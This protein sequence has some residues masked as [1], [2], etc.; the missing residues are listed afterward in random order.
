MLL[1]L[2]AVLQLSGC[3]VS[4]RLKPSDQPSVARKTFVITGASSGFGRGVALKLAALQGDVVLAARRTDVL[5]E[6]A[7]QIRMAG[8]SALVVTTDVSNPNEMQDLARAAIE[9]FGRIDVWINNAAVGALGRFEDVPVEDHAR[10]VDVNLKG[11]IYGSHAAMRQFR[12]QGFGTLV[13]VGSV[14]SEIP[15]A[16]HAS[17]AATKGGVINLGA[18]I[19]EE[20][21]LSGSETINVATV[22]P[23]AVDTPFLGINLPFL[24]H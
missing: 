1:V 4:P 13:N 16:Y 22:M 15:L 14:E 9:R 18:A 12:A 20:I 6:L 2:L 19:A 24:V 8:G 17:S 7:A 23:W 10:I 3:A 11:M 5:E 21:R